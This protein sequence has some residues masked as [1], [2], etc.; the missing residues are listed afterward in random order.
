MPQIDRTQVRHGRCWV[1][2][3]CWSADRIYLEL[4]HALPRERAEIYPV[5]EG[6]CEGNL[7]RHAPCGVSWDQIGPQLYDRKDVA[8]IVT[9]ALF[10]V[11]ALLALGAALQGLNKSFTA[12]ERAF[13]EDQAE[14]DEID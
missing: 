10:G 13:E 4:I 9:L 1:Q 8:G 14:I 5:V 2:I 11:S 3:S 12:V 7:G 6:P